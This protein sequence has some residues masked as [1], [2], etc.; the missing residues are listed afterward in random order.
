M[1]N[2]S[3]STRGDSHYDGCWTLE[4]SPNASVLERVYVMAHRTCQWSELHL[5]NHVEGRYLSNQGGFEGRSC[6]RYAIFGW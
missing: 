5:E 4:R 3:S 6:Q 1:P 2:S